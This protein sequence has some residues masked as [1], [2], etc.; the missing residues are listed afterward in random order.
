MNCGL[1]ATLFV[2]LMP[3][4]PFLAHQA[5]EPETIKTMSAG[6]KGAPF[7]LA[8]AARLDTFG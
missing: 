8:T 1:P 7:E 4:P 3:I 5:F 2:A 6:A